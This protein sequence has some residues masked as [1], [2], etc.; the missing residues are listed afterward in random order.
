MPPRRHPVPVDGAALP[1]PGVWLSPEAFR[2]L[3]G[4]HSAPFPTGTQSA[5]RLAHRSGGPSQRPSTTPPLRPHPPHGLY[6]AYTFHPF[7]L[8]IHVLLMSFPSPVGPFL[9]PKDPIWSPHAGPITFLRGCKTGSGGLLCLR[10]AAI[11]PA[12][13]REQNP[14][15]SPLL[16]ER[17]PPRRLSRELAQPFPS[18]FKRGGG[19]LRFVNP[20]GQPGA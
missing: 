2:G 7:H 14:E 11:E 18:S 8:P 1:I 13:R 9:V 4:V 3:R 16:S 10:V 6:P 20:S 12:A 15:G 5:T 19:V 17:C